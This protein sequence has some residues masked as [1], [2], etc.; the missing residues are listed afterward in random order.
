MPNSQGARS[1]LAG[2]PPPPR[3]SDPTQLLP[4][5]SNVSKNSTTQPAPTPRWAQSLIPTLE[6]Q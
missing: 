5:I 2:T 1:S 6:M 4:N 3:A